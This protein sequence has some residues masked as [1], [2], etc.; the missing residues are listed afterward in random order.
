M[1]FDQQ[2]AAMFAEVELERHQ[3]HGYQSDIALPF[4]KENPFSAL[5]VD[6]GLGKSITSA[7][8]IADLLSDFE[9]EKVLVIGPLRVMTDTWPSEFRKWRHTAPFSFTLI[10]EDDDDPRI[11]AA[12]KRDREP[13]VKA[14]RDVLRVKAA[15]VKKE[16]L[17][18]L[19]ERELTGK[20]KKNALASIASEY[21]ESIGATFATEMRLQLRGD[22]AMSRSSVHF[23]NREQ[24]EWLVNFHGPK[25]PYRTVI[26]D[27]SS[28]F[29]DHDTA[30]FKAIKKVRQTPGLITRMHL[31]TATP[32]AE[33]YEHLFAQLYLLDL[34]ERLGKNITAYREKYFTQNRWTLKWELREGCDRE[35]L[36]KIKDICLVMKAE[37]YLDLEKPTIVQRKVTLPA[38]TMTL[39]EQMRK[40]FIVTLDDGS[41]VEAETAAA[42]SSKLL[43]MASG[44]LY[45]TRDVMDT[46]TGDVA[47]VKTIHHLHDAKIETLKEIVESLDGEPVLVAYHFKSSLDRLKKAF[48]K[49]TVMDREGKCVKDW[50]ARKLPMLLLHPQSGGHGLNL[51][52]GGHNIVFFDL[53]W[54]LELWI[55]LIGRLARQGQKNPVLV[56]VLIAAGTLDEFVMAALLSKTDVQDELFSMLKRL[57]YAYRKNKR[58][59][60]A[61]VEW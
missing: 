25:W 16:Q 1:N 23:I 37:D 39:Y 47:A 43:Q 7:T 57:I 13:A 26:I 51:Q 56:Q 40:D 42:L 17:R 55:Q 5:F 28:S 29:K 15:A 44:V 61:D 58:R 10:R 48:P 32:A 6:M 34:G 41:E 38:K 20:K 8:L 36:D 9:T 12:A 3:M 35:I 18:K 59:R 52:K 49:A 4:L 2:I 30:R 11:K 45:E 33:S 27:E 24:L 46:G 21:E 31:L 60:D 54:S 50:N 14:A 19:E 22:L 53:V